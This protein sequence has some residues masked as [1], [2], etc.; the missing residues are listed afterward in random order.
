[1]GIQQGNIANIWVSNK[2]NCEPK[3]IKRYTKFAQSA[4]DLKNE[5]IDCIVMVQFPAQELVKA[6]EGD[7]NHFRG[8]A[9]FFGSL[10]YCSSKRK[11]GIIRCDKYGYTKA[12]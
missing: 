5:K 3:E 1:M 4:K 7:F 10:D 9:S 8:K 2:E 12:N 6:S 11:P